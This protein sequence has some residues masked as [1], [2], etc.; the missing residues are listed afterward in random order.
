MLGLTPSLFDFI[1]SVEADKRGDRQEAMASNEHTQWD[2]TKIPALDGKTAVVTGSASGIGFEVA[3]HLAKRGAHVILAD[4]DEERGRKAEEDIRQQVEVSERAGK[5]EFLPVDMGKPETVR[6]FAGEVRARFQVLDLL[7]NNAGISVAGPKTTSEGI[8]SHFA[9]NYLG[10][11]LLTSELFD[12]LLESPSG[13]IVNTSSLVHRDVGDNVDV[14]VFGN[15]PGGWADYANSKLATLLFTYELQ[16][17]LVANGV[18][19]VIAVAAHPSVCQTPLFDKFCD[20]NL[21][22]LLIPLA[23]WVFYALPLQSPH[24][25]ALPT[26][27]AATGADAKGNEYFGP[28][29]WNNSIGYPVRE[30]SSAVSHSEDQMRAF[31]RRSEQVLG[32]RFGVTRTKTLGESTIANPA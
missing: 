8:E 32:I 2:A 24:M 11:F 18:N 12:L 6:A 26:L 19:N 15:G 31:W 27:Y 9:I 21:P 20:T 5:V 28:D 3:L 22:K 29:R 10:H 30:E 23:L 25:G 17:Q 16:H 13:R 7:V 14:S 4:C 1:T